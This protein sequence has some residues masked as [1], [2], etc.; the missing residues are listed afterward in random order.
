MQHCA[1]F[2]IHI[3]GI[4]AIRIDLYIIYRNLGI[5][6]PVKIRWYFVVNNL[7]WNRKIFFSEPSQIL[8]K[9]QFQFL[10]AGIAE[11]E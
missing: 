3:I 8:E 11:P 2:T 5:T 6:E 7:L 1:G 4:K 9:I 10:N